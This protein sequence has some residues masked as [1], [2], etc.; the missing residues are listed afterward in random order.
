MLLKRTGCD[1]KSHLSI[2]PLLVDVYV[3]QWFLNPTIS[4]LEIQIQ[5]HTNYNTELAI[6]ALD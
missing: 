5:I 2:I 3:I 6:H 1:E 4:E